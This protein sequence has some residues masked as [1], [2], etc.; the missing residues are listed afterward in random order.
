MCDTRRT[1]TA[2]TTK[3]QT[4]NR[5]NYEIIEVK[6]QEKDEKKTG[7]RRRLRRKSLVLHSASLIVLHIL[8]AVL[9]IILLPFIIWQWISANDRL[10]VTLELIMWLI[11]AG[12]SILMTTTFVLD[13]IYHGKSCYEKARQTNTGNEPTSS[14]KTPS[15]SKS[16]DNLCTP[17]N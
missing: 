2:L 13:D 1:I 16:Q 8:D 4:N 10:K 9:L 11:F 17:E 6:E 5:S 12:V 14:R 15:S 3:S 7:N